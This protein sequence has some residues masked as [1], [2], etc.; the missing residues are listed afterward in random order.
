MEATEQE[1]PV[2]TVE[3][4]LVTGD[5]PIE[6]PARDYPGVCTHCGEDVPHAS[7]VRK[8]DRL[9]HMKPRTDARSGQ[10]RPGQP[11]AC[12]PVRT[13]WRYWIT[14]AWEHEGRIG[15]ASN[16]VNMRVP[17]RHGTELRELENL[18]GL[19]LMKDRHMNALP[20]VTLITFPELNDPRVQ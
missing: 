16:Q 13:K 12:G 10:P 9:I 5:V 8:R 7:I 6:Q 11:L 4:G 18:I 3:P 14:C 1:T 19:A 20:K 17:I 2:A 15:F